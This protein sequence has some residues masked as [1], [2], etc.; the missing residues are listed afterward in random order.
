MP[1]PWKSDGTGGAGQP[2]NES[3]SNLRS[4]YATPSLFQGRADYATRVAETFQ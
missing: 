4:E 2:A 3:T 1:S